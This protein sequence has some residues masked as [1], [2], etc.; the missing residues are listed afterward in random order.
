MF[1][2]LCRLFSS[3][4]PKVH[5]WTYRIGRRPSS[6]VRRSHSLNIFSSE[7]TEPIK[8]KFHMDAPWVRRTKVCSNGLGHMTMAAMPIYGKHKKSPSPEPKGRWPRK[9][10]CSIGSSSTTKIV[11]MMT[12]CWHWP[13]LQQGQIWS[14]MHLYGKKVKQWVFQ[15]LLSSM[16][17]SFCCHQKFVSLGAVCSLPRGHM[18]VLNHEKKLYKIRLQIDFFETCKKWVKW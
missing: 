2:R 18:H 6:L 10:V 3:P 12:L 4:E 9:L 5:W 8:V 17:W 11:Q 13:T 1:Y 7:T 15:T 16:I 14:L